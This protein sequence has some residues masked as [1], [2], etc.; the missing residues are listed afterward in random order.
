[1]IWYYLTYC[2]R[3]Y[4]HGLGPATTERTNNVIT[5][6]EHPVLWVARCNDLFGQ[7]AWV[8]N[9][10]PVSGPNAHH[11]EYVLLAWFEISEE[12]VT[13]LRAVE[14]PGLDIEEPDVDRSR[15]PF[16][17]VLV[18]AERAADLSAPRLAANERLSQL[19]EARHCMRDPG[20][21][22]ACSGASH[23]SCECLS[24]TEER[25]PGCEDQAPVTKAK[26]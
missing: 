9:G 10:S 20:P 22:G 16:V 6:G 5:C 2:V 19:Q 23:C 13:E 14:H 1:M 25:Y 18:Q 15:A 7:S 4:S 12:L 21:V 26:T 11:E 8:A 24:C 17:P 3:R